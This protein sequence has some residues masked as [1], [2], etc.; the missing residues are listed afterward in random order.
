MDGHAGHNHGYKVSVGLAVLVLVAALG[1]CGLVLFCGGDLPRT[2]QL[3]DFTPARGHL[4]TDSCLPGV[5]F[6]VPLDEIGQPFQLALTSAEPVTSLSYQIARSLLCNRHESAARY[7]LDVLRLS[8]HIRRRFSQRELLAIYANRAYFGPA[9]TGVENASEH[10]FQRDANTLSTEEAALL[11]GLLRA[12]DFFS[13]S[14]H[15]DRA[16]RR[17][18]EILQT[19]AVQGKLSLT[20]AARAIAAP[21]VTRSVGNTE[22]KPLV[23]GVL[24]ALAAD[25][26]DYCEEFEGDF[27]KG[28]RQTFQ[29]NLRWSELPIAPREPPAILVEIFN[30]GRIVGHSE[31]IQVLT[32]TVGKPEKRSNLLKSG[33]QVQSIARLKGFLAFDR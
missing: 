31:T 13:P 19:M 2:D 30:I 10:I 32:L 26:A 7:Q 29:A 20:E 15:L 3:S 12:P 4:V 8:W 27:K 18:N 23:A 17:R 33:I 24:R 25:E 11:A 21:L 6:A 9:A 16:L 28:C 1:I 5:S 22:A 14:K